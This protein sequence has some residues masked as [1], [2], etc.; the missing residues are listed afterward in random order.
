MPAS[1][2]RPHV[3][4]LLFDP[5]FNRFSGTR[6]FRHLDGRPFTDKEQALASDAIL[7]ELQAVGIRVHDPRGRNRGPGRRA[8]N[9][10]APV[11][12][13]LPAPRSPHPLH[14]HE[15]T[16]EYSRLETVIAAGADSLRP[17][18]D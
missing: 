4:A 18:K 6:T 5:D 2:P 13:R 17:H 10:R 11:R 9:G 3:M 7:E 16:L 8:P 14:D 15:D 1:T 12:V